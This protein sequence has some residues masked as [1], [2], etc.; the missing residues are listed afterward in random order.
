[1]VQLCWFRKL[2]SPEL[3]LHHDVGVVLFD[4]KMHCLFC[5][6]VARVCALNYID[7]L[8]SFSYIEK[9]TPPTWDLRCITHSPQKPENTPVSTYCIIF[10][11]IKMFTVIFPQLKGYRR[12]GEG[13]ETSTEHIFFPEHETRLKIFKFC[14][15]ILLSSL[16]HGNQLLRN[17]SSELLPVIQN[18]TWR[19]NPDYLNELPNEKKSFIV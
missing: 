10:Y 14:N 1:M 17:K 7:Q 5:N 6:K 3:Q 18:F 2:V 16:N 4:V 13:T 19:I 12:G 11:W 8:Y 15:K 9:K